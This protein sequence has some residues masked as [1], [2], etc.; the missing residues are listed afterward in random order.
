MAAPTCHETTVMRN[1]KK[2]PAFSRTFKLE[3]VNGRQWLKKSNQ[4]NESVR[5]PATVQVKTTVRE[6]VGQLAQRAAGR[7][8]S[9]YCY[10]S[11]KKV[12]CSA[13]VQI[14]EI[15][16]CVPND[17]QK[18]YKYNASRV[19]IREEDRGPRG[20]QYMNMVRSHKAQSRSSS[21]SRKSKS[22]KG[23]TRKNRNNRNQKN[24]NNKKQN[25]KN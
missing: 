24:Q 20:Q 23:G 10:Q 8:F 18:T 11:G 25:K 13:S 3:K 2:V 15:T 16:Q 9:V 12:G 21:S 4:G 14:R 22:V 5:I 1:G 17:R 19:L 7:L 6:A